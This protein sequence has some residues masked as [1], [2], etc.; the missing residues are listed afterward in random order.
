MA[1]QRWLVLGMPAESVALRLRHSAYRQLLLLCLA[2]MASFT[3][4]DGWSRLSSLGYNLLP[5]VMLRGFGR[6][7]GPVPFGPLPR[8]LYRGLG[9]AALASGLAWYLT[10]LAMRSTGVVM[11]VLWT[12]FVGWSA[13]RLVRGLA[14]ERV[15]TAQVLMGAGAGYLLIGLTAGL[16]FSALETISPGS[17]SSMRDVPG[18]VLLLREALSGESTLVWELNFVRIN[19]F[20]FVSLTTTGFGDILPA[21]PPAQMAS[22]AVAVIGTLYLAVVMGLLISRYTVQESEEENQG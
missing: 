4:P 13:V 9:L 5:L 2:V 19:Y 22:V 21:T 8:Q 15:V 7:C 12:L 14:Q 3:L 17:F 1:A 18:E 11:L 20:A 10:P 16:L 6:Q